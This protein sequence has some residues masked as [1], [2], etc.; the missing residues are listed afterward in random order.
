MNW[1]LAARAIGVI[2]GLVLLLLGAAWLLSGMSDPPTANYDVFVL[3]YCVLLVAGA[4]MAAPW[5]RIRSLALWYALFIFLVVVGPFAAAFIL[6]VNTWSAMHGAG[7]PGYALAGLL[8]IS[9]AVQLPA[10]WS[11]R[12][13]RKSAV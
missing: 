7:G 4:L 1:V 13:R 11:L 6:L 3:F 12:P 5:S 10:I 2:A 9:W 8:L